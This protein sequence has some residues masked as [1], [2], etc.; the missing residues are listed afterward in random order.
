MK[1][2]LSRKLGWMGF[3]ENNPTCGLFIWVILI[4]VMSI[5]I[6]EYHKNDSSYSN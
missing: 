2:Q 1:N 5:L 4:I 3:F 6:T